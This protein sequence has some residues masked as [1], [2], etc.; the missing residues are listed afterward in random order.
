MPYESY[1]AEH[2]VHAGVSCLC[3]QALYELGQGGSHGLQEVGDRDIRTFPLHAATCTAPNAVHR[4]S[5]EPK[6]NTTAVSLRPRKLDRTNPL[7]G[8]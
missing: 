7:L 3:Q 8:K 2:F 6:S 5:L 1:W 4:S